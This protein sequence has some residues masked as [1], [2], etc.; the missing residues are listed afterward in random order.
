M[1]EV[2]LFFSPVIISHAGRYVA[3]PPALHPEIIMYFA[4][5]KFNL[6]IA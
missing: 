6:T 2:K 5:N 4:Y 1:R 3:S